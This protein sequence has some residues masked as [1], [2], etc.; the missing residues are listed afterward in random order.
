[1][2]YVKVRFRGRNLRADTKTKGEGPLDGQVTG[3]RQCLSWLLAI[4]SPRLPSSLARRL[5]SFSSHPELFS[6]RGGQNWGIF[7]Q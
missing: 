4:L 6:P 1:M 3:H 7:S 2:L 5:L